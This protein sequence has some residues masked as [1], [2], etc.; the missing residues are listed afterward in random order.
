[1]IKQ[2]L[3]IKSDHSTQAEVISPINPVLLKTE[4]DQLPDNQKLI[5]NASM[6]VYFAT[7]SQLPWCMKEI[8]RLREISF[9][10]VGEGTGK[11]ADIDS[12]DD[13][14][15][16]LFIWNK[17]THEIIGGYRLGLTDTIYQQHSLAGLYSHSLFKYK[18]SFLFKMPPAIELGRSFVRVEQQ[19]NF[20][21]LMLLWKGICQF[22][23][24]HPEYCILFGPVSISNKY[25]KTSQQLLITFLKEN[26]FDSTQ[27]RLIKAR[28]PYKYKLK[29]ISANKNLSLDELSTLIASIEDDNKGIPV[30]IR[31][32]LKWGGQMLG[33][34]IDPDFGDCID[35]LI[36]VDFRKADEKILGKY[37]GKQ[38]LIK[39]R[40]YHRQK[41]QKA[42]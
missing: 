22:I 19:K 25:S 6:Q 29:N 40:E 3:Q 11:E 17:A 26:L 32:Y 14:Y 24:N 31:Q 23:Y 5:E 2:L 36:R 1:M 9:R 39:Y 30:L 37:M 16:Q 27:G 15:I 41:Y 7:A 33:F 21:P 35:G 20:A 34:N 38:Q 13:Y 8:G 42:G 18:K 28:N 4:I 10:H 12:Y